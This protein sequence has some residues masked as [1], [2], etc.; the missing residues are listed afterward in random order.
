MPFL[1]MPTSGPDVRHGREVAG[2]GDLGEEKAATTKT[3]YA[4]DRTGTVGSPPPPPPPPPPP[5]QLTWEVDP[6]REDS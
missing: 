6:N 2:W 4:A 3:N 5:L 1:A